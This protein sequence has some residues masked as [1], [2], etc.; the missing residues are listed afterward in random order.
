MTVKPSI[1]GVGGLV[2]EWLGGIKLFSVTGDEGRGST[3]MVGS[4]G[5]KEEVC[6]PLICPASACLSKTESG[7]LGNVFHVTNT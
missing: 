3:E 2:G 7:S 6:F 4:D 1:G 5:K